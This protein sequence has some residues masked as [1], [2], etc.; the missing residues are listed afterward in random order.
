MDC[1]HL[2]IFLGE[3]DPLDFLHMGRPTSKRTPAPTLRISW[4]PP[5]NEGLKNQ[6]MTQGSGHISYFHPGT[7]GT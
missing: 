2:K 5:K 7:L 6:R 4:D 3:V 1:L